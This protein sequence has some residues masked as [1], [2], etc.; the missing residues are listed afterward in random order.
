LSG[1]RPKIRIDRN[2]ILISHGQS[3]PIREE[4]IIM[5]EGSGRLYGSVRSEV[6]WVIVLN[7]I[8]DT[9]FIQ[10]IPLEI[11]CDIAPLNSETW[12]TIISTGGINRVK[13]IFRSSLIQAS[14]LILDERNFQFC[15]CNPDEKI[16]FHLT[17]RNGGK[18]FLSGTVSSLSE[19]IEI[20]GKGIW[21]RD[22]Q[23]IPI[24]INIRLSPKVRHPIGRV[25]VRTNGGEETVE[26]SIHRS[27]Q[28]G[29]AATLDPA[30]LRIQ[31]RVKGV[32]EE[33]III[34]NTG[35]GILRGTIPSKYR[36]I[37]VIPSIF[38]VETTLKC[39]VRVDTRLLP[40]SA[41]A[42][43]TLDVITNSGRY[44]LDI[45]IIRAR[46]PEPP[47]PGV[48][49]PARRSGKHR[50]RSRITVIDEK[51]RPLILISSGKA[52]GEGE[53]WYVEGDDT[54]CVKL[55]HPHRISSDLEEKLKFM[56]L[57]PVLTPPGTGLCWPRG[58]VSD[59]GSD[60]RFLGYIMN[61]LDPDSFSPAHLWYD[62]VDMADVLD[63]RL[64]PG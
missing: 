35:T 9:T 48:R 38:S 52:G 30:S 21:T 45:E 24:N 18:G 17:V 55:F 11:R 42:S 20:P 3:V 31:W 60:E 36:W 27:L 15:N 1:A 25:L 34:R 47:V 19:W 10:R 64:Q 43:V 29:P 50:S 4:L 40:P 51:H 28:K 63:L 56:E 8:L 16:S 13:I 62:S 32:I 37:T 49:V 5:N 23:K 53:I 22:I 33:N 57:N 6:P 26:V 61:R 2:E 14:A 39:I 58:R 7:D 59:Q 46:I 12:I 44:T 54:V 41:P